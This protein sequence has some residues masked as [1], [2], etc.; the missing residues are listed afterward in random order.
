VFE[1]G[2][3]IH[4][5]I[6]IR[7]LAGLTIHPKASFT[8]M[9]SL[10][11]SVIRDVGAVTNFAS[12]EDGAYISGRAADILIDGKLLGSFGEYNPQVIENFELAYPIAGFEISLE[13]L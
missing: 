6:T 10:V 8:E 4:G 12:T 3:V 2:D 11:Q 13:F 5:N 9:K 1:I 7:H